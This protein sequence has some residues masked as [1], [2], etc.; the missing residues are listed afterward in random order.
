MP[1]TLHPSSLPLAP[2]LTPTNRY[3][4]VSNE[5]LSEIPQAETKVSTR[6]GK[7]LAKLH[8]GVAR[9]HHLQEGWGRGEEEWGRG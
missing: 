9:M 4:A 8:H 3:R 6:R 1:L 7:L 2:P 5:V